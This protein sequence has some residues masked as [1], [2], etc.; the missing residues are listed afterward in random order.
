MK[1]DAPGDVIGGLELLELV[2]YGGM[3]VVWKARAAN[4]ELVAV[5]RLLPELERDPMF[6]KLFLEEARAL[7][8]LS[9]RHIVALRGSGE[10]RPGAH[11]LAMQWVDGV[12]LTRFVQW[13]LE[14][15]R[16]TPWRL[17]AR[18]GA[19]LLRGLAAAHDRLDAS[20]V[21]SPVYHR[22]ISPGNVLLDVAGI[23]RVADFGVARAMDRA[24]MT[25]PGIVK[26]KIGYV[27]PE[28]LRA[29]PPTV[30]SDLWSAG[31]VLWEAFAG[32]RLFG[33][34]GVAELLA[35]LKAPTPSLAERRPDMPAGIV[36]LVHS[37]LEKQPD[38]RPATAA[39]CASWLEKQ[40]DEASSG[41]AVLA[42]AVKQTM[43]GDDAADVTT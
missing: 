9:H 8:T 18:I 12:D 29:K 14:R 38:Q 13:H 25:Q 1:T 11:Y 28:A 6:V 33:A 20:G 39:E 19:H 17:V 36:D 7:S 4:G 15:E 26:G 32:E 22:D 5:K 42:L 24:S 30:Q 43:R 41:E 37:F 40:L 35:Q 21:H 10:V 3:A 27:S 31:V 34:K 2:A 16:P 23:A